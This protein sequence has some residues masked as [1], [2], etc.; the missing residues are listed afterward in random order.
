MSTLMYSHPSCVAHDPGEYHPE[1]PDRLRAV[2]TGL[3]DEAFQHLHRAEAPMVDLDVVKTVHDAGYVDMLMDNIPSEGRFRLDPDTAMSAS[4]GEAAQRAAGAAVDA[5][6]TVLAGK[7]RNAFCAVRPPGHH[8]ESSQAMGFCL[9]NSV[10]IAAFHARAKH[11]LERVCV[12]DFDVHHGNGTQHSFEHVE[13]MFYASSHQ[14][15]AYPGTGDASEQGAHHNICN[16]P[17]APGAGSDEFRAAYRDIVLPGIRAFKP[18]L[19]IISAGFDA[20]KRDPL[21][22]LELETEDYRW[23]T[24]ELLDLAHDV[25]DGRAISVLEGGYDLTALRDSVREHVKSLLE[26]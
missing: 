26:H 15:P 19:L 17:L 20:H 24:D 12:I 8:A 5:V 21:A 13:G 18:E 7:A 10:A 4:S 22:Q 23:V 11:A 25:C 1:R 16:A 2:M 3:E 14:Y 6:D 9:F